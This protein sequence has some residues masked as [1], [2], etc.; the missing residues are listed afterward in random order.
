MCSQMC[1][2]D[3]FV[4]LQPFGCNFKLGLFNPQFGGLERSWEVFTQPALPSTWWKVTR[5]LIVLSCAHNL[6]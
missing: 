6:Q 5:G 4:D 3:I 2:I 1:S